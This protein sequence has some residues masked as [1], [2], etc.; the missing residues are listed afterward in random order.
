MQGDVPLSILPIYIS[1]VGP[2]G[3]AW[4]KETSL[5][6]EQAQRDEKLRLSKLKAFLFDFGSTEHVGTVELG[7]ERLC[8]PVLATDLWEPSKAYGFAPRAAMNSEV[9]GGD[10]VKRDKME[11]DAVRMG[12]DTQFWFKAAPGAIA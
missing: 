5:K 4:L 3:L 1:D 11:G 10:A 8:T 2:E 6:Q 9:F 7:G 12:A